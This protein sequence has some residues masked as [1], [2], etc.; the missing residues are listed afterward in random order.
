MNFLNSTDQP[1]GEPLNELGYL[2]V[3]FPPSSPEDSSIRQDSSLSAAKDTSTNSCDASSDPDSST[4]RMLTNDDPSYLQEKLLQDRVPKVNDRIAFYSDTEQS[5]VEG[6]ITHDL[7]RRWANYFNVIYDDGTRDGLYLRPDTR[8]TFLF[9]ADGRPLMPTMRVGSAPVSL[10]PTPNTSPT[11]EQT[12]F[13][14]VNDINS[15]N[16]PNSAMLDTSNNSSSV[17]TLDRSRDGSMA[18]DLS[19]LDLTSSPTHP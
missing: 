18:W 5:W 16:S 2:N 15:C 10:Q 17:G 6:K 11:R 3:S 14:D 12:P 1:E 7:T 13:F 9:T 8:W 4:L 19:Y